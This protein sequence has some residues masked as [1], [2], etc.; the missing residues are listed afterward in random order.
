MIFQFHDGNRVLHDAAA[1]EPGEQDGQAFGL[2]PAKKYRAETKAGHREGA[3]ARGPRRCK[4][5]L[6]CHDNKSSFC[7]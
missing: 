5:M 2:H 4:G 1:D 7:E 6:L 3:Q